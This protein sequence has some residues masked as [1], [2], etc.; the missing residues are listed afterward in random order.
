[1][2]KRQLQVA[3]LVKRNFGV[4]LQ[5]QGS[6]IYGDAFV[7]VTNVIMSPDFGLAKIYVSVY[8]VA[9]KQSVVDVLNQ[10]NASL[11]SSLVHR[12]RKH[13]RRIPNIDIY[14]D[15]TLDEMYQLN[16]L[17]DRLHAENKMGVEE[18]E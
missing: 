2:G 18:E 12:I 17:F 13:V 10:H 6:Y 5:Q 7:T 11:K 14:L 3:E 1:M 16:E 4:V 9:D 8:N 15:E